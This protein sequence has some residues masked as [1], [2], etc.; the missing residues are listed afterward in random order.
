VAGDVSP[1]EA[2]LLFYF[3]FLSPYAFLAWTQIRAIAK[4]S[5]RSL[6]PVPV[7]F[8]AL[9]DAHGQKGPA[10]IPAKRRYLFKDIARKAHRLGIPSVA[11]P[12]AHPFNPLLSLRIASLPNEPETRAA[13]IDALYFAAWTRRQ[14]IDTADAV[15]PILDGAGFD[16]HALIAAA[17]APEA[18]ERLRLATAEAIQR[19]VFGVPSVLLDGELYW[20]TDALQDLESVLR[21]EMPA[22]SDAGW[23]ALPAAAIRK[24]SQNA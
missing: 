5:G 18:K 7:L 16:G 1:L 13:I 20:G 8:A 6:E 22:F 9:L 15:T 14:A 11:P 24:G 19:G 23:E 21:G 10:E 4:R 2:P 12:P 3:D 17:Q